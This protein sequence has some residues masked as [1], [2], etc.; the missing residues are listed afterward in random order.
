MPKWKRLYD[1]HCEY[2]PDCKQHLFDLK[3]VN[4][5]SENALCKLCHYSIVPKLN[6]L[7]KH[8]KASIFSQ[9]QLCVTKI[10]KQTCKLNKDVNAELQLAV[11]VASHFSVLAIDH[12]GEIL[13][14]DV[15]NNT[16]VKIKMR[17]TQCSKLIKNVIA[18][19]KN[20]NSH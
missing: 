19:S 4:D 15:K 17:C 7:N 12:C 13:G 1:D 10:T 9:Q 2:N 5:G 8:K 20:I 3:Y 14:T 18:P 6:M 11:D 16:F